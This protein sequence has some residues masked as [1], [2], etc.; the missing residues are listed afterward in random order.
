MCKSKVMPLLLHSTSS[1]YDNI[2]LIQ[3]A[4]KNFHVKWEHFLSG[5]LPFSD[6]S[7]APASKDAM[8]AITVRYGWVKPTDVIRYSWFLLSRQADISLGLLKH[9]FVEIRH[10]HLHP[11]H[12]TTTFPLST[13]WNGKGR[14]SLVCAG[15]RSILFPSYV[16]TWIKT[17]AQTLV[18]LGGFEIVDRAGFWVFF[19]FFNMVLESACTSR[20]GWCWGAFGD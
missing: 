17:H 5:T 11:S 19:V 14:G 6:S 20:S 2:T 3:R 10:F 1:P 4:L 18:C 15:G 9:L 16:G 8:P 13:C 7:S 12:P